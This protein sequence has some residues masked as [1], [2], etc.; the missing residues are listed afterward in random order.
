MEGE[1]G[2][3]KEVQKGTGIE[4][5]GKKVRGE[6]GR[7]ALPQW[8]NENKNNKRCNSVENSNSNS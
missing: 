6:H 7:R 8:V 3:E 5:I 1:I 4:L 2:K